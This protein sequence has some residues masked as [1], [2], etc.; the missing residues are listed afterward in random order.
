MALSQDITPHRFQ[1]MQNYER[2]R[3]QNRNVIRNY[4]HGSPYIKLLENNTD[5]DRPV[6]NESTQGTP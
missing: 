3:P 5:I 2:D 4:R 6:G 1:V